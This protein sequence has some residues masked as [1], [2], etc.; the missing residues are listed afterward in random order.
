MDPEGLLYKI[1]II[2]LYGSGIALAM[3][4][5]SLLDDLFDWLWKGGDDYKNRL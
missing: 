5:A 2:T 3:G 4:I 1:A